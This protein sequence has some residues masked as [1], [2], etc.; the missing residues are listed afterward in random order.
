M[1]YFGIDIGGSSIKYG[2]VCLGTATDTVNFDMLLMPKTKR[3][4]KYTEA[5]ISLVCK[6]GGCKGIGMGFPSVVW[7]DGIMNLAVKYDDVWQDVSRFMTEKGIPHCAINDADAAG[8]A[9][10][11][12]P[13]AAEYRKGVTIVL[14]LGTGIGSA[15]FLDGKLLPNS[16]LG[17][18]Y[19]N[20]MMAEQYCAA[21]IKRRDDLSMQ[22]WA[23]RLQEVIQQIETILEPDHI[24]LGGG[25]SSDFENYQ[26]YMLPTN[27]TISLPMTPGLLT[28]LF[29]PQAKYRSR[30]R[31]IR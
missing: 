18:I 4:D 25:I 6:A 20:N 28:N 12:H 26:R 22:D 23:G 13:K 11:N 19:I 17:M 2:E 16:E 3:T 1:N 31:Y 27:P 8:F 14:T 7:K 29:K 5:L 9:E 30:Q 21:S 10:I 24:L 15:I